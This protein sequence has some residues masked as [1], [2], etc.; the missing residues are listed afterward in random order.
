MIDTSLE[1][2]TQNQIPANNK[3]TSYREQFKQEMNSLIEQIELSD[4]QRQFIKSRWMSQLLWLESRAQ[5]NRN[6]YYLLRLVTI[7]GGVIVPALVSLNINSTN[8]KEAIGW[9]AFGLSQAVAI[10]AAVE[11]FFHYGERYRHYR[12]TAELM[13]IEAWQFFQLS[14]PY[15]DASSHSQVYANFAQ[16][17]EEIMKRDV[18]GYISGVAQ[19]KQQPQ[20]QSK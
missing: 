17:V 6:R 12:N 2:T 19:D 9:V 18:E 1:I 7:I 11:E 20:A 10:S 16:R 15:H 3:P 4:L 14:G 8:I 5:Q 13:K